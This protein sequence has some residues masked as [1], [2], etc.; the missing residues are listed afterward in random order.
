MEST[1]AEIRRLPLLHARGLTVRASGRELLRD[2]NFEVRRGELALLVGAS[3]TGKTTLLKFFAGIHRRGGTVQAQG[4]IQLE[5]ENLL[6]R[7]AARGKIGILFQDHA[8]FDELTPLQNVRFAESHRPGVKSS[9]DVPPAVDLLRELGLRRT[10]RL[11]TMSGGQLQRLALA[12]TLALDPQILLYDEPTAGLDPANAEKVARLIRDIHDRSD[13][14]S[15]V[16]THDVK[17]LL[18]IA[19]RVLLIDPHRR[20]IEETP[21]DDLEERLR[22]VVA[23]IEPEAAEESEPEDS[24]S[25]EVSQESRSDTTLTQR[26]LE[27]TTDTVLGTGQTFLHLV[28][29]Y[30]RLTYGLRYLRH[31]LGLTASPSSFAYVAMAG[32]ILGFVS[33]WFTFEYLPKREFSEPLFI[34]RI[35]EAMGFLLYRVLGPVLL[36]ILVAA[37]MGAA[38]ASDIG[39]KVYARQFDA[40]RSFG[41]EPSR[42][43]FTS[44]LWALVLAMPL[45]FAVMFLI[46]RWFSLGVFVFGHPEDTFFFW[47][48]NFHR[49]LRVPDQSLW[50][51]SYWLLCKLETCAL[52]TAAIAYHWG[53]REKLSAN[54]VS[55]SVTR[56]II[57]AT[58]FVLVV[59]FLFAF[60]EF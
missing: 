47:D 24:E 38:I 12:R 39:N 9:A 42:Y 41:I 26:F 16:V 31:F 27:T 29:L 21:K 59:H 32:A 56:T 45:L 49:G 5:G 14:T 37:R 54:D 50:K 10:D 55:R 46:A 2:A 51:G 15:L 18:P 40:L 6:R 53:A 3:G 13:R 23:S 36:T 57:L 17:N 43:L 8:L 44:V 34:E 60:W 30:P 58:L 33:T 22:A 19:D 11:R 28:P 1:K 25:A 48:Q 7:R 4:E 35:L 52:G 20:I